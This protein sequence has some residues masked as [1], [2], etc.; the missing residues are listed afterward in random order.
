MK[1]CYRSPW[2]T[3]LGSAGQF[4]TNQLGGERFG[5]DAPSFRF[6]L[7]LFHQSLVQSD[8]FN[9]HGA[10]YGPSG[11][12]LIAGILRRQGGQ[13]SF[14]QLTAEHSALSAMEFRQRLNQFERVLIDPDLDLAVMQVLGIGVHAGIA[15]CYGN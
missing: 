11:H 13:L 10:S 8:F 4:S 5:A 3:G 1:R 7:K 6:P 14:Q 12:V 15:P 9:R 2:I